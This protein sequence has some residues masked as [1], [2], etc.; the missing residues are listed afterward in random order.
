MN[1]LSEHALRCSYVIWINRFNREMDKSRITTCSIPKKLLYFSHNSRSPPSNTSESSISAVTDQRIS[2]SRIKPSTFDTSDMQD[3]LPSPDKLLKY[4]VEKTLPAKQNCISSSCAPM[5]SRFT[6]FTPVITSKKDA[7]SVQQQVALISEPS[8]NR[9]LHKKTIPPKQLIQYP[10]IYFPNATLRA[11]RYRISKGYHIGPVTV[12]CAI[13]NKE[14]HLQCYDHGQYPWGRSKSKGAMARICS[15]LGISPSCGARNTCLVTHILI[16]L[17]D[18][19]IFTARKLVIN[20]GNFLKNLLSS[21]H[22]RDDTPTIKNSFQKIKSLQKD[23]SAS[24]R[25]RANRWL[26]PVKCVV[27]RH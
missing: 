7:S 16:G 13:Q 25:P 17:I 18:K 6:C 12:T 1:S 26:R 10:K 9:T 11:K 5:P 27:W 3:T 8:T 14:I 22:M 15:T 4:L 21:A 2:T 23:M 19:K 24:H 20:F